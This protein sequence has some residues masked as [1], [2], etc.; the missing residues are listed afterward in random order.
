MESTIPNHRATDNT[1]KRNC[2]RWITWG[3]GRRLPHD[4]GAVHAMM[5]DHGYSF[6]RIGSCLVGFPADVEEGRA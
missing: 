1:V 2:P 4:W 3:A 5:L 6:I